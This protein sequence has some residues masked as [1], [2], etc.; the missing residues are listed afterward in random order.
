M[1]H[2][3]HTRENEP[4][5]HW[6]PLEKHLQEVASRA[7]EFAAEFGV[8]E[9]GQLAGLWHDLGKYSE[10]FQDYLKRENGL[11]AHLE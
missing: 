8:A 9:W 2:Y 3:A 7:G 4:P 6:E 10:A 1:P 11:E 5:E